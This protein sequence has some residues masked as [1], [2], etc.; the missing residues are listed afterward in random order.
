MHVRPIYDVEN[1]DPIGHGC[2]MHGRPINFPKQYLS[3]K[4]PNKIFEMVFSSAGF[5]VASTFVFIDL[6]DLI[7][8]RSIDLIDFCTL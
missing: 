7:F 5:F 8:D 2:V 1:I 6:L 4:F 3:L